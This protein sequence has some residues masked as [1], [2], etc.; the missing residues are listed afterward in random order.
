MGPGWDLFS[1]SADLHTEP[2]DTGMVQHWL[3]EEKGQNS[4]CATGLPGG[5][6]RVPGWWL[7]DKAI[8]S[9]LLASRLCQD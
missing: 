2:Q 4:A 1:L 3:K 5:H 9:L 8:W 6:V 7:Q